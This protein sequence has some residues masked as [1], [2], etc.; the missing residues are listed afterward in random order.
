VRRAADQRRLRRRGEW[1]AQY[2]GLSGGWPLFLENLRLTRTH[3]PGEIAAS[4]IVN[5]SATGGRDR[6]W[7]ELTQALG[8]PADPVPGSRVATSAAGA[9]PLAGTVERATPGMLT[10]L[11]DTPL[12]G[13][14][15]VAAE[16]AGDAVHTSFYGYF[17]GPGAPEA[18]TGTDDAW[19]AWMRARFPSPARV[20]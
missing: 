10:L 16:G 20:G 6:A 18:A 7:A 4:A 3:F 5:G 9:P 19:T 12:A 2:D 13:I 8:L 17:F 14:A 15:F 1:D 11:V